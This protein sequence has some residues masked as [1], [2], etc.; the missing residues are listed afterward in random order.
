MK[1][2]KLYK[3]YLEFYFINQVLSI[4]TEEEKKIAALIRNVRKL[5]IFYMFLYVYF[6]ASLLIKLIK[7]VMIAKKIMIYLLS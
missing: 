4:G 2:D 1:Y 7:N 5:Y 6:I 3:F